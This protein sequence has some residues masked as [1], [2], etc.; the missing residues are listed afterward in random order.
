MQAHD[1]SAASGAAA[2]AGKEAGEGQESAAIAA[3]TARAAPADG[4]KLSPNRARKQRSWSANERSVAATS[5]SGE[6]RVSVLGKICEEHDS[7]SALTPDERSKNTRAR[8]RSASAMRSAP[9]AASA[10]ESYAHRKKPLNTLSTVTNDCTSADP[11]TTAS[12]HKGCSETRST[13]LRSMRALRQVTKTK[14]LAGVD[15]STSLT[16]KLLAARLARAAS[17][18]QLN[19]Q[20]N[21]NDDK[22]D[23]LASLSL[24]GNDDATDNA[25]HFFSIET[26]L[27]LKEWLVAL[28]NQLNG[29]LVATKLAWM[30][31]FADDSEP[32]QVASLEPHHSS[33]IGGGSKDALAAATAIVTKGENLAMNLHLAFSK[34]MSTSNCPIKE[35]QDLVARVETEFQEFQTLVNHVAQRSFAMQ[36]QILPIEPT[37]EPK[38]SSDAIKAAEKH[39]AVSFD[40]PP[41][42]RYCAKVAPPYSS[43]LTNKK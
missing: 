18:Q 25:S 22:L 1:D 26:R 41:M 29:L 42:K 40:L 10:V 14:I 11:A 30:K 34:A 19:K 17:Q 21:G 16:K 13:S 37:K 36:L 23:N 9:T 39:P 15:S 27:E 8:G 2:A 24:H 3:D 20:D 31:C 4:A 5:A 33:D 43:Y 28:Q 7:V 12:L 32:R 38:A 35:Y 6:R